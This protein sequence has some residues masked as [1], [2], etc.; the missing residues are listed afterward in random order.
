MDDA[1]ELYLYI[2][3]I[4]FR[5]LPQVYSLDNAAVPFRGPHSMDRRGCACCF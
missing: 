2:D 4:R 3:L 1:A 5:E